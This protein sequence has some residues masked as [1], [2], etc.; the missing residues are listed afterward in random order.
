MGQEVTNEKFLSNEVVFSFAAFR[1]T[2]PSILFTLKDY[3][4]T[5]YSDSSSV[6]CVTLATTHLNHIVENFERKIVY[7]M[8]IKL[9]D[10]Y[11]DLNTRTT[12]NLTASPT[13]FLS[14]L[15][16]I[17]SELELISDNCISPLD[18][19]RNFSLAPTPSLR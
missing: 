4:I 19:P 14:D 9:K 13:K 2:H 6:A 18:K 12:T 1:Q 8:Q 17:I 3:N 7:F 16:Y 15:W 10:V 11:K 5:V